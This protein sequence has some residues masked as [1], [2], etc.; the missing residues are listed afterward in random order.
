MS[1]CCLCVLHPPRHQNK[2]KGDRKRE[3]KENPLIL[4]KIETRKKERKEKREGRKVDKRN[5]DVAR[6][7]SLFQPSSP[8][9]YESVLPEERKK[10][11]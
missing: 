1:Y 11:R 6:F 5:R 2:V 4:R 7:M 9:A 8:C 3:R 10:T